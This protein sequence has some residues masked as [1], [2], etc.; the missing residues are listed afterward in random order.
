LPI[1]LFTIHF[2]RRRASLKME[3]GLVKASRRDLP[4]L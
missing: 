4:P 2:S 1:L 3:V